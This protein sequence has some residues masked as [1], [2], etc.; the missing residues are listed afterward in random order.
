M[1]TPSIGPSA[2]SP[3][4]S[5]REPRLGPRSHRAAAVAAAL[6]LVAAGAL[7]LSGCSVPASAATSPSAGASA[8]SSPVTA[9]GGA[10]LAI[11]DS[12]THASSIASVVSTASGAPGSAS[13]SR[14]IVVRAVGKVTGTPDTVTIDIGVQTQASSA[15]KALEDNNAKANAVIGVLKGK[16]IA[17]ADLQTSELTVNPTYD[18][19]GTAITGYQVTNS[20]TATLHDVAKA[21]AIIDAAQAAA[22]DAARIDSL[23]F[24]IGDGS[25]LRAAARAD[26]VKQATAAANQLA[27]A[28]GVALGEVLSITEDPQTDTPQPVYQAADAAASGAVPIQAGSQDLTVTVEVVF[29]IA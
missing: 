28:A 4:P 11:G 21:G 10:D 1:T 3:D 12:G 16:G 15:S 26:A 2:Q 8:S 23:T 14:M 27:T 24:S 19:N 20:L 6:A 7:L 22:G 17:P 29:A 9:S 25:S 13:N 18:S 5:I